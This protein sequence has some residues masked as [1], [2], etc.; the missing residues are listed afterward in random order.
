LIGPLNY[1][2]RSHSFPNFQSL[3]ASKAKE[4]N[5][6]ITRGNFRDNLAGTLVHLTTLKVLSFT[7]E[8]R[9][10]IIIIKCNA[11]DS[12]DKE[13]INTRTNRGTTLKLVKDLVV[14]SRIVKEAP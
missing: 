5:C 3:L 4:V 10:E 9:V 11:L 14:I 1:H 7:L 6:C 13:A 12:K 8:I 2:L